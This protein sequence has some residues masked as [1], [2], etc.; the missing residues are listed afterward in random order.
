MNENTFWAVVVVAVAVSFGGMTGCSYAAMSECNQTKRAS[1]ASGNAVA[2]SLA[3][4]KAC[5]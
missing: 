5:M 2:I 1:L 3:L 4:S